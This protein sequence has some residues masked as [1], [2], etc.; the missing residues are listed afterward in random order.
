MEIK[1]DNEFA[2]K[3]AV[4]L[5]LAEDQKI[6]F[7]SFFAHEITISARG[8]YPEQ[9]EQNDEIGRLVTFNE[10]QHNITS[11]MAHMLAKDEKRYPDQ[12]FIDILFSKAGTGN[13]ESDLV[14]AFDFA[15]K[16]LQ[17]KA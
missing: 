12:V 14:G 4:F 5:G 7:L 3:K 1:T 2:N 6:L 9:V 17:I 13:C 8:A 10:L 15:L 11:Q 16:H